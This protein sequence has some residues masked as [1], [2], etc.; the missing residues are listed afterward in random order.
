LPTLKLASRLVY[1]RSEGWQG[2]Q[3]KRSEGNPPAGRENFDSGNGLLNSE[4]VAL[5]GE[6]AKKSAP[7]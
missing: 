2:R 5:E 4:T 6:A 1:C 7:E 3:P